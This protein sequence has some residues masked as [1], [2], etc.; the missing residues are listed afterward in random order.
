MGIIIC[1]YVTVCFM[2]AMFLAHKYDIRYLFLALC[3]SLIIIAHPL[4]HDASLTQYPYSASV[5]INGEKE[6]IYFNEYVEYNDTV[7]IN[8]YCVEGAQMTNFNDYKK[9][10]EPLLVYLYNNDF[11]YFER[12][13]KLESTLP[14]IKTTIA[15]QLTK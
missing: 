7:I 1:I 3:S 6:N 2:L 4:L 15:Y 8:E 9:V 5:V 13:N 10:T 11:I 12:E 14:I